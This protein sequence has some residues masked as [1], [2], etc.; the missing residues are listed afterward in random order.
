MALSRSSLN[1]K[2]TFHSLLNVM[3]MVTMTFYNDSHLASLFVPLSLYN[4]VCIY[5][6]T[7]EV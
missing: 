5:T 2:D 7:C 1:Q 3:C 6:I 4:G